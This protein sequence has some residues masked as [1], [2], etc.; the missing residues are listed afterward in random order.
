M[1]SRKWIFLGNC[2]ENNWMFII[3]SFYLMALPSPSLT[4]SMLWR[5]H[6]WPGGNSFTIPTLRLPW[7]AIQD[8]ARFCSFEVT[9]SQFFCKSETNNIPQNLDKNPL[10]EI[11]EFPFLLCDL[12]FSQKCMNY[13]PFSVAP[14]IGLLLSHLLRYSE[15]LILNDIQPNHN[16]QSCHTQIQ[17]VAQKDKINRVQNI[18]I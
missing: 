5:N 17:Q 15:N 7:E 12:I 16:I 14:H 13:G 11:I 6:Y 10:S 8:N 2:A 9:V 3:R 4:P 1:F 18:V